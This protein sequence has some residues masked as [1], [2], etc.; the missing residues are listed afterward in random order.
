VFP[1]KLIYL[2]AI[3]FTSIHRVTLEN[4][5]SNR[6]FWLEDLT[7]LEKLQQLQVHINEDLYET[8][9]KELTKNSP[10]AALA[11]LL[12]Q[13]TMDLK[14]L[15]KPVRVPRAGTGGDAGVPDD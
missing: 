5:Y 15:S 3:T 2:K 8:V 11:E 6:Y 9:F 13:I 1:D 14:Q 4:K 12:E 10:P 7:I